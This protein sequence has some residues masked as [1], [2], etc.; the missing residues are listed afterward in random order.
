MVRGPGVMAVLAESSECCRGVALDPRALASGGRRRKAATQDPYIDP[1]QLWHWSSISF[2]ALTVDD[3]F[4]VN[5]VGTYIAVCAVSWLL[6]EGP[7]RP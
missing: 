3:L 7:R 4:L 2:V 1:G 6:H 5:I